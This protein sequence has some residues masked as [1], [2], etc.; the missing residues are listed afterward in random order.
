[1][2][3]KEIIFQYEDQSCTL[4]YYEYE[5]KKKGKHLIISW[6]MH[7]NEINWIMMCHHIKKYIEDNNIEKEIIWKITIIPTLNILWF[8]EMIRYI[9]IDNKDLNRCFGKKYDRSYS[10]FYADFLIEN[11]FQHA[12][13]AI[14]IHDAWGRTILIPH[15]RINSCDE[16]HC[17]VTIHNMWK[18]FDSKII[19]ERIWNPGML[20]VYANDILHKPIMTIEIWWN[21]MIYDR[22]YDDALRWIVNIFKWL[23]YLDWEPILCNTTQH[24]LSNRI[25]YKTQCGWILELKVEIWEEVYSWDILW[26]IYYPLHDT[27]ENI[28]AESDWFVFSIRA[29]KQIPKDK[30]MIS[31]IT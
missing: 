3:S 13:H 15:A 12:D 5:G 31:I 24:H 30:D 4:P 21:Q 16:D 9:P 18:R 17:N 10:E 29:W 1:M 23:D 19:M 20:A 7:G 26:T 27:T 8:Q 14:D 6:W 2:K 11:F 22:Y 28:I 25:E